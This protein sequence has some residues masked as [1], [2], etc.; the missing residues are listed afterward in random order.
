MSY[1]DDK[2]LIIKNKCP[3]L[4]FSPKKTKKQKQ[5]KK[6]PFFTLYYMICF[7]DFLFLYSYTSLKV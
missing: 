4:K 7:Y 6:T 2:D 1:S 3:K 5:K